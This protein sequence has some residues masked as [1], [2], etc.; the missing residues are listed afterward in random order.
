MTQTPLRLTDFEY[1][2]GEGVYVPAG[3]VAAPFAYSDGDAAENYILRCVQETADVSD[4]SPE[5]ARRSRDWSSYYHLAAGR[6]NHIRVLDL[7]Q[8]IAVLE[9]GAGCGAVSRHLGENHREVHCVEGSL[10]RAAIARARCRG[11][12]NVKLYCADFLKLELEPRYDLVLLNGVLEYAPVFW[13]GD[14]A[15][16]VAALLR[17]AKSALADGGVLVVAIENKIGL[18][19]WCGASE[20][21]TGGLFDGIHGYPNPG[22]AVT[23]SK[24]E[25]AALLAAAGFARQAFYSCF[26]DYKFASSILAA[27]EDAPRTGVYLHNWI[28]YPAE[29]PGLSRDYTAHEGLAAKT[30][31][32]AGLIH[33]FANSFLVVAS[34]E[35]AAAGFAPAMAPDWLA[36]KVSVSNRAKAAHCVTK[37]HPQTATVDKKR[38]AY[39]GADLNGAATL[40]HAAAPGRWVAGQ[41]LGLEVASAVMS[42][43]FAEAVAG[44]LAEYHGELLK[45]HGVGRADGAGFPLV[46]GAAYDFIIGN[47]IRTE[48]GGLE[49]VDDE[50]VAGRE[51]PVDYLLYRSLAYDV[52]GRNRH[53]LGEKIDDADAFIVGM[54]RSVYPAYDRHRH[55]QNRGLEAEF[56]REAQGGLDE[57]EWAPPPGPAWKRVLKQT[58]RRIPARAR[59]AVVAAFG[60]FN[61]KLRGLLAD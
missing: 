9:L 10:R 38:I 14:P 56:L 48:A 6:A 39:V 3:G 55:E 46:S 21:H 12:D 52:I 58:A 13:G 44:L 11:L 59:R 33:E 16:A 7:P 2:E 31:S 34:V 51:L 54:I 23:Y 60:L 43:R 22:T 26:P 17:L 41:S 25:L 42:K 8:D 32:D 1:R 28:G 50:W 29:C 19:Y 20:D 45:Q 37:F 5:L 4:N 47:L 27:G 40:A 57:V 61:E 24:A 49:G 36:S 30:L 18:K 53:W 35:A 15:G